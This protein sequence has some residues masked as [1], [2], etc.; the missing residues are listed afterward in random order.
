MFDGF[1]KGKRVFLTGH[2]GFKGAWLAMWLKRMG[3]VVGA[4]SLEPPS[5][6][7]LWEIAHVESDV[8]RLGGDIR[9]AQAV[10]NAMTDFRP[11]IVVHMAAQSLVRPSYKY[12][13]ETFAANIMGTAH[14][15]DA[16]RLTDSVRSAIM[17]TSDKCYENRE[18]DKG[19][20]EQDP[21][22]GHDPYSAS[23]GCAELVISSYVR[24]FFL[25]SATAIA[26]VRA[27]NVIGGGDFATDRLIPDMVRAFKKGDPVHIRSPK[28]V[29]P[30]QHVL[31]PVSGYLLLAKR[32]WE[33]KKYVGAWNFG[34]P[35]ESAR[36]VDEVVEKFAAVWGEGAK[37]KLDNGEHPHEATWL[38][39]DCTKAKIVLRWQPHTDFEQALSLTAEWY[40]AWSEG[41]DPRELMYKQL[42]YFESLQ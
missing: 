5:V 27:G 34:P 26:S 17:I 40:K 11:E 1:Y 22:G 18:W 13:V 29:R 35:D 28:S 30:W 10:R 19:Y 31:E 16:I 8:I 24:S 4:F 14:V 38:K 7:S 12:P 32:L 33:D 2:T 21:M 15:L 41:D 36:T 37:H 23:K 3:A 25:D 6:P 42:N 20:T 9:D 39:L